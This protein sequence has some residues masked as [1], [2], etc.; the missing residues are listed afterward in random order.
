MLSRSLSDCQSLIL[1]AMIQVSFWQTD[2]FWDQRWMVEHPRFKDEKVIMVVKIIMASWFA[3]MSDFGLFCWWNDW[4]PEM[5]QTSSPLSKTVTHVRWWT[6]LFLVA[7]GLL[8]F[9]QDF[10]LALFWVAHSIEPASLFWVTPLLSWALFWV[11][12]SIEPSFEQNFSI[13][14]YFEQIRT[15]EPFFERSKEHI[16]SR[17]HVFLVVS[18]FWALKKALKRV[19][20]LKK[21]LSRVNLLFWALRKVLKRA[22]LLKIVL[23]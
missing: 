11:A 14:H 23:N 13:E 1:N 16:Y 10:S 20:P 2:G 22:D 6:P 17:E 15:F 12:H 21:G 8:V 9:M 4:R 3:Q 19:K 5:H 18:L 7:E